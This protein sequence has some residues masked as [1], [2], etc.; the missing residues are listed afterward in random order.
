MAAAV[1]VFSDLIGHA[2]VIRLLRAEV[3]H[4]AQSYLFVGPSNTGKASAARRFAAALLCDDDAGCRRRVMEGN[5]P[6][7]VLV[8]PEG[9]QS[10]TVDQ[11]RHTVSQASLSPMEG[12]RKVFLFEEGGMMNDEAANALLKTL[13]EP[14]R[15]TTFLIVAESDADLP[16]TVSSRCRRIVF[17][18][19]SEDEI[20]RGLVAIGIEPD[21]ADQAARIS[22]G[23]PGLA[24]ALATEPEAAG[25]RRIWLSVP[26]RLSDHPGDAFMLAEEVTGAVEPLLAGLRG[27]HK[28]EAAALDEEGGRPKALRERH[29]RALKRV[30]SAL[31]VSGLE[32]LAAFYRDAA[33]A[34]FGAPVRNTDVP[35]KALTIVHPARAMRNA[36]RVLDTVEALRANQRPQLALANLFAD[37]GGDS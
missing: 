1:D 31:Y 8:E 26:L 32:I 34:Q 9:R 16:E 30:S 17:G 7:I 4:P 33:A 37:L 6:D 22:G 2:S 14:T 19:V 29:D 20:A 35:T 5:H 23:R 13:E 25:F 11:A 36:D 10:I 18:R 3:E 28:E 27:R 15:S 12:S 21:Q 24:R